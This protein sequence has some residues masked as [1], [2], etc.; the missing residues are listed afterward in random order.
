MGILT[1]FLYVCMTC[2]FFNFVIRKLETARTTLLL[3]LYCIFMLPFAIEALIRSV[4]FTD[5]VLGNMDR[6]Y[7]VYFLNITILILCFCIFILKESFAK[8]ITQKVY[9]SLAGV[10]VAMVFAFPFISLVY[11]TSLRIFSIWG[12]VAAS[13][14]GLSKLID[15]SKEPEDEERK[16]TLNFMLTVYVIVSIW[17]LYFTVV[18]ITPGM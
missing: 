10:L 1:T 11:A 14:C 12:G 3:K 15:S 7:L 13:F 6:K 9:L 2:I 16:R 4:N 5:N 8:I 18:G 17:M